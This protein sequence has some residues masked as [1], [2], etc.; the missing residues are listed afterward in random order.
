MPSCNPFVSSALM[1]FTCRPTLLSCLAAIFL[2]GHTAACQISM[3]DKGV[4]STLSYSLPYDVAR[5]AALLELP[6]RMREISGLTML[7]RNLLGAV[8][9]EVGELFV[10]DS[11][12]GAITN[13]VHFGNDGDY[14][15]IERVGDTV[16]VVRSDGKLYEIHPSAGDDVQVRTYDTPVSKSCNAEGLGVHLQ[17]GT[18]LIAC[19]DHA[20][21]KKKG[22]KVVHAFDL[23][24]RELRETPA[25]V[26]DG[27]DPSLQPAEG[28]VSR[29]LRKLMRTSGFRPS[30]VAVHP[31]NGDVYVVSSAGSVLAVFDDNASLRG[32]VRLDRKIFPQPEGIT[33]GM[34]GTLF[35]ATEAGA[36]PARIGVFPYVK[37]TVDG[38]S[39]RSERRP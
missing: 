34:D 22:K 12:S 5:P 3:P 23:V 29:K 10:L 21:K 32:A 1:T 14:E 39:L 28:V 9:D 7:D 30:G 33:F 38:D 27:L 17:S 8:Q 2:C 24:S 36:G 18:L 15:G 35:I 31:I 11:S 26:I 16:Y 13:T 19:K 20:G 37:S 25:L 4:E 6:S